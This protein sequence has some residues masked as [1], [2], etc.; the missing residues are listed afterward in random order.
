MFTE[1]LSDFSA[2]WC[3][4]LLNS[5][6]TVNI[7]TTTR[8]PPPPADKVVTNTCFSETFKSETT[9]RAWQSLQAKRTH[10]PNVSP[11]FLLLLSL[12]SGL[13]GYIDILHGGMFGFI[14]DQATSICAILTAGPTAATTEIT[15]RYKRSVPLPSV[16]LC[17]SVATKRD[18]RKLWVRGTIEDETETV[19]CEA[20]VLFLSGKQEKL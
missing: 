4:D 15:L 10:P 8:R 7:T 3:Q 13:G 18:G 2:Q 12:G 20:D 9:I 6:D 16:I 1:E 19:Y 5:P 14:V 17:R 11:E